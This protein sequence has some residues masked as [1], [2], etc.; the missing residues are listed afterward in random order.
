VSD[1]TYELLPDGVEM[2][3]SEI[4]AALAHGDS[5]VARTTVPRA[6][7][8]T[9]VAVG[10]DDRLVDAAAALR[11]LARAAAVRTI[12][13]SEGQ[14]ARPRPRLVEDTVAISGLK[15]QFVDNAV[16][17]LRVSSLPTLVWWRGGSARMLEGLAHLADRVVLDDGDPVATWKQA[18]SLLDKSA[19][20][21]LRWTRLTR[22][23]ALMAH[24]FDVPAVRAAAPRFETLQVTGADRAAA[25]L[26][27]GWLARSLDRTAGLRVDFTES[28]RGNFLERIALTNA[29]EELMI[30]L[31]RS[32]TCV[33]TSAEVTGHS[34]VVRMVSLGDQSDAALLMEELRIRARDLAF[35]QALQAA[36]A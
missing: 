13:I 24:F 16:A 27:A 3:F 29:N 6:L 12:L 32:R 10:P 11:Q 33:L 20:S 1:R 28:R 34:A 21:D 5:R 25:S 8:A 15:A 31:G 14:Q 26:F 18:A 9:I 17:A 22:W 30:E 7:T 19:F 35:E 23:R 2:P 4:A 36:V